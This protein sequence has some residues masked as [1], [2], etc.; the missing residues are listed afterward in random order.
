LLELD[1]LVGFESAGVGQLLLR[2]EQA[3]AQIVHIRCLNG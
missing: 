2:R 3:P 1:D